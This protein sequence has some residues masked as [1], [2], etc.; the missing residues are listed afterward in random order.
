METV[1]TDLKHA[2]VIHFRVKRV[3]PLK[4]IHYLFVLQ[5]VVYHISICETV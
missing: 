3:I 1:I 5:G 2:P 4:I